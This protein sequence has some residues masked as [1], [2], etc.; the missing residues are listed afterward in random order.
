MPKGTAADNEEEMMLI[1]KKK[2]KYHQRQMAEL[3]KIVDGKSAATKEE[4]GS[5]RCVGEPFPMFSDEENEDEEPD[6]SRLCS[7]MTPLSDVDYKLSDQSGQMDGPRVKESW[8]AES[9]K[10]WRRP[11]AISRSWMWRT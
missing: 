5:P 8:L 7:R 4:S 1:S 11:N 3:Q 2:V 6:E 9:R 10:K